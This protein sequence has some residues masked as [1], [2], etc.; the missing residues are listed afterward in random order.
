MYVSFADF[1]VPRANPFCWFATCCNRISTPSF[2]N[3]KRDARQKPLTNRTFRP[4]LKRPFSFV[5]SYQVISTVSSTQVSRVPS[6]VQVASHCPVQSTI[7]SP[8]IQA[9]DIP[10][11]DSSQSSIDKETREKVFRASSISNR[12]NLAASKVNRRSNDGR[13]RLA[14]GST[15]ARRKTSNYESRNKQ[16][17]C[18]DILP[19]A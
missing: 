6:S 1:S 17:H 13:N 10:S 12:E 14:A 16:I 18:R 2:V 15:H 8:Q 7:H 4:M 19:G 11:I 3:P 9:T 5:K